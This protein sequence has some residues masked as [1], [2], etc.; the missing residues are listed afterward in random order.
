M[1]NAT[2]VRIWTGVGEWML[3]SSPARPM[4]GRIDEAIKAR[5]RHDWKITDYAASQ[6]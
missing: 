4:I 6:Y 2:P 3:Q 1:I 5:A